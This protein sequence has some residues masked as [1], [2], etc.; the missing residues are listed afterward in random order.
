MPARSEFLDHVVEMMRP[1]GAVAPRPMFG[2]WGLYRE[3]LF[4]ALVFDDT[5]YLKA[6]DGNAPDFEA[7]GLEAFVFESRNTGETILTSYRRAPPEALE[8]PEVMAHWA[9][10]A[11]GAALRKEQARRPRGRRPPRKPPDGGM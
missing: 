3:G 1:F 11:Y 8:S 2:G 4:F 10:G 7:E 6:D 5:L 9:R